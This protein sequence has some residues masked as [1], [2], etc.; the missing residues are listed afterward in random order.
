MDRQEILRF[1]R[2][3]P[4]INSWPQSEI[5]KLAGEMDD[6]SYPAEKEV[7][8]PEYQA[9]DAYI[10]YSGK[11]RQSIFTT[12]GR[13]RSF[14]T[15]NPRDVLLQQT[16]YRVEEYGSKT[17]AVE[18]SV[19]L[20][21]PAPVFSDLLGKHGD[22]WSVIQNPAAARLQAI[23]LLR[24]LDDDPI[25]QL[26]VVTEAKEFKAGDKISAGDDSGGFLWIIDWGQVKITG[27]GEVGFF[28][29]SRLQVGNPSA[30]ALYNQGFPSLPHIVTAGNWFVTGPVSLPT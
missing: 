27:Q 28:G 23:P 13:E 11:L 20:R 1:L 9:E 18:D 15:F 8:P 22:L 25:R 4:I 14:R 2:Q 12:E 21:I 30:A 5:E 16:L 26:A 19:L 10:V 3:Q 29:G 7:T 17:Y 6:V 24:V